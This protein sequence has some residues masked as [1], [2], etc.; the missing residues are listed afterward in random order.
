LGEKNI[1]SRI[2]NKHDT[3]EN[4]LKASNFYPKKGE[5]IVYDVDDN[6]DYERIK[7]GDGV[8]L[9]S[10]LP[11]ANKSIYEYAKE[12]G[13][14]GTED[15]FKAKMAA[16]YLALTGGDMKGKINF[17]SVS[18]AIDLGTAGWINGTTTSGGHFGVFGLI[19]PT[20]LQVGGSYPT[21]ELK[22][23]NERPTYNGSDMAL[24]S[25]ISAIHIGGRNLIAGTDDTT[26]FSGAA[27]AEGSSKDVWTGV[28]ICPPTGTEYVVS[29]DAKA[30]VAMNIS[31]YFYSPN[32]TLTSESSTGEKRT[33]VV[34]G[35][36][37]VSITTE[38]K[39]Y[40]VKWT[41]TPA[42]A[43][44]QVYIGRNYSTTSLLY[45]RAVKLE[46]GNMP[47]SWTPA[48]EDIASATHLATLREEFD[49]LAAN[50]VTIH[51]GSVAPLNSVGEEGDLYLYTGE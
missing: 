30:D 50:I 29:F 14:T 38:W 1:T 43:A 9:V 13:Y 23:K 8:T 42:D 20:R 18:D 37:S 12:S 41:Q 21:L 49:A 19:D 51:S 17:V 10:D 16:E 2:V 48:P 40:W 45:I 4:W 15:E 24:Y 35:S 32:T 26:V 47:S 27:L 34:D 22:G 36:S 46:E 39:R 25:D 44:K 3:E 5:L 33:N 11:F 6:H 31:C 7:I 28:T